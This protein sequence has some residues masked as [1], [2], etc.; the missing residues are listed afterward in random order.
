MQ[1]CLLAALIRTS[2]LPGETLWSELTDAAI[3]EHWDILLL[4]ISWLVNWR[5]KHLMWDL[6]P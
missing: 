2:T 6:P 4:E 5:N 3:L 1:H